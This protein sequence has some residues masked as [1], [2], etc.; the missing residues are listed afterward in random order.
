MRL[1]IEIRLSYRKLKSHFLAPL[2]TRLENI[3]YATDILAD[4]VIAILRLRA[5]SKWSKKSISGVAFAKKRHY[6]WINRAGLS[7]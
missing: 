1:K 7:I 3:G 6:Q 4:S 2:R 5:H